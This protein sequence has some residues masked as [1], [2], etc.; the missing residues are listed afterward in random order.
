MFLG[1]YFFFLHRSFRFS[2][3]NVRTRHISLQSSSFTPHNSLIIRV[4][5]FS[6]VCLSCVHANSWAAERRRQTR[7]KNADDDTFIKICVSTADDSPM[8]SHKSFRGFY[9][10]VRA[11]SSSP[12][13]SIEF[14]GISSDITSVSDATQAQ[15]RILSFLIVFR[16]QKKCFIFLFSM[17]EVHRLCH[18]NFSGAIADVTNNFQPDPTVK[19]PQ[20]NELLFITPKLHFFILYF[21][22]F[23]SFSLLVVFVDV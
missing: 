21:N 7:K 4:R 12:D 8:K 1:R 23:I 16:C 11:S 15:N 18:R 2:T 9:W 5:R 19:R 10:E 20:F 3:K 13:S 22:F 17:G 6:R 14:V